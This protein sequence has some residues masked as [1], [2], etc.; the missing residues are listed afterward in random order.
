MAVYTHL[1]FDEIA[2]FLQDYDVGELISFEGIV[3]GIDNTN[4]KITANKNRVL[5]DYILTVFESRIDI[6]DLPFFLDFMEHCQSRGINCPAPVAGKNGEVIATILHKP[7]SLFPFLDGHNIDPQT[8]TPELCAEL[9]EKLA[10]LHKAGQDFKPYRSN[11]MGLDAWTARLQKVATQPELETGPHFKD[12]A[13]R[14]LDE[15]RLLRAQ[16]PQFATSGVSLLPVGAIH[17]DLFPDNVFETNG[18]LNGIIDFYFTA[19]D[20]LAYDLAIVLNAWCFGPHHHFVPER[21]VALIDRYQSVRPL[22]PLEQQNFQILAKG[23][24]LRFLSSRLHDLCFHD[25]LALVKPK[26]PGE[27]VQKFDFHCTHSLF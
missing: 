8:I 14:Y 23:A 15:I 11:S 26:D 25:A 21:W 16:W 22:E 1:K 5:T 9:G 6:E 18:H 17:A 24:A 12:M 20:F 27:Y 3:Q 7:A 10:I 2:D 19:T 4:Y 13:Q